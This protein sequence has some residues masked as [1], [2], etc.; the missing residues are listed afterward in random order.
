MSAPKK[1]QNAAKPK[2]E[3]LTSKLI[4]H[5]HPKEKSAWVKAADGKLAKWVRGTLNRRA[6]T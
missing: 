4:L 5:C 2:D 1:N 6:N 3:Q